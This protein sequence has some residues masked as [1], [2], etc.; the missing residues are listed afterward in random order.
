M[1]AINYPFTLDLFG[2]LEAVTTESKI[3]M[4]RM[5]TLLS[6]PK[7]QR[8]WN[9]DYGTDIA[10]AL[11]EN[12]NDFYTAAKVAITEAMDR[13][14]PELRITSLVLDEISSEGYAN[15]TVVAAL[16]NDRL[17]SVTISSA[18][19]GANGLIESAAQ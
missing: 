7:G 10:S 16:P 1:R 3:Y 5:L 11:F 19:F 13:W 12:D 17:T 14:L 4:D 6:T 2:K 15:I 18:V 8:P 9:P